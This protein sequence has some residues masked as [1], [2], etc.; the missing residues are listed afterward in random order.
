MAA[1][2][3]K[4]ATS[5]A[6]L[7]NVQRDGIVRSSD[8]SRT[9]RER[10]MRSGFLSEVIRGWL[11][12][13]NPGVPD[14]TSTSWYTSF[15]AFVSRYLGSR[16]GDD[17]CLAAE[18]SV[19]RHVGAGLI[20]RQVIVIAREPVNQTVHLR[21]DTSLFI[22]TTKD[23]FPEDRVK[24]DGLWLMDLPAALCRVS[25]AFFR[26]SPAD[27]EIALRSVRDPGELLR[28]LLEGGSTLV[29][30]RLAGAYTYLREPRIADQIREAMEAAGSQ[31]R[32]TNPF[33]RDEPL[34]GGRTRVTSP[35]ATR[36][37]LLWSAMR[38]GVIAAFPP[39]QAESADPAIYLAEVEE[40]YAADAYNS[41][42]IEGYRVSPELIER[43]RRGGWNPDSSEAD[44]R[45][46]DALAA[47]G[48]YQ[49]FQAVKGSLGEIL[50]GA[51][52]AG[53]VERDH[54]RW[55]REMFAP[56]VTAGILGPGQLAGYRNTPVYLRGS[57][58]VPPSHA[59]VPDCMETLFE[60]LHGE[61]NPAVRAV[62]GHFIFVYIHP[63]PDGNGRI[64][65]FLMNA[66]FASARYP[67]TVIRQERRARYLA[68][69]EDASTIHDIGPFASFVR[70]EMQAPAANPNVAALG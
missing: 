52:P 66:M 58:Y 42:S 54:Q 40:R 38:A 61:P 57:R 62:L 28:I 63:Y 60:L 9:H 17:Y 1:P 21:F 67:W 18:P 10:L 14:G 6:L 26:N 34:L 65:R 24:R 53:I 68:A 50:G 8:L 45:E 5:L 51:P 39:P 47:R 4:L 30:G 16:F 31:I 46:A 13:T 44:V 64:A 22:Y 25:P 32:P 49:A 70:E 41:L 56:A 3:D 19:M 15:W 2:N 43:V 37:G 33:E 7:N 23:G 35:H 55:C 11:I 27:G 12:V 29:A 48:Y 36:M 20:P 69:L 59:A